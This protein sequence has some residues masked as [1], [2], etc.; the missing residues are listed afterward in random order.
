MKPVLKEGVLWTGEALTAGA[1][2]LVHGSAHW[3][4]WLGCHNQFQFEGSGGHFSARRENRKGSDYWYAYRRRN[5]ILHKAYLGRGADLTLARLE[6]VAANLAG[7]T[8]LA[9]LSL[10]GDAPGQL[11]GE[12]WSTHTSFFIQAKFRPPVLPPTLVTR[13]RLTG[14]LNAPVT[15]VSAPAASA[16]V[17]C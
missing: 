8:V 6:E 7:R 9:Q 15:F 17:P 16:R 12:T 3:H 1:S 2:P 14:N 10:G 11:A 4:E 5:G 13:P